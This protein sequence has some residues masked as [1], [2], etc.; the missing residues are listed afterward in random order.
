M[1]I[2]FMCTHLAVYPDR[3][4]EYT[5]EWSNPE[6]TVREL[7]EIALNVLRRETLDPRMYWSSTVDDI[8]LKTLELN[9]LDAKVTDVLHHLRSGL[10]VEVIVLPTAYHRYLED[11]KKWA[12]MAY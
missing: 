2:T 4:G 10:R 8:Q 1:N 12:T 5:F 7:R 6:I 9:E 3:I 11:Q